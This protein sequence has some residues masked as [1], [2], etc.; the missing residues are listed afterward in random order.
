MGMTEESEKD[1]YVIQLGAFTSEERVNK[2]VE[3]LK[4]KKIPNYVLNRN[5]SDGS[6]LFALRAGPFL[7]LDDAESAFKLISNW[8]LTPR[9]V[10]IDAAAREA[11]KKNELEKIEAA[12]KIEQNKKNYEIQIENLRQL[13]RN[14][15]VAQ[16][17]NYSIGAPENASGSAFFYPVNNKNGVCIYRLAVD[18]S[19]QIMT[20]GMGI[21]NEMLSFLNGIGMGSL[22][23][24]SQ[25]ANWYSGEFDLNKYDLKNVQFYQVQ[26]TQRNQY[27]GP[28]ANLNYKTQVEGLTEFECNS[29]VCNID[30]LRNGWRVLATKCKGTA[31]AF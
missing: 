16:V 31:K 18:K 26:S 6:K 9:I 2:W 8:G 27:S 7:N 3:M 19:D 30:R 17:L 23:N 24:P 28:T 1:R 25:Q 5:A 20:M 11:A 13:A 10:V 22:V 29:T 14:D 4:T 21:A 15:V 12:K